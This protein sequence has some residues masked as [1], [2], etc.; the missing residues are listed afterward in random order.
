MLKK[1]LPVLRTLGFLAVAIGLLFRVLHWPYANLSITIGGGLIL[2]VLLLNLVDGGWA[3]SSPEEKVRLA[4]H[5]TILYGFASFL[6]FLPKLPFGT[7]AIYSGLIL[8][9]L[10]AVIRWRAKEEDPAA[11]IDEIGKEP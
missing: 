4:G 9:G 6:N 5:L 2:L 1:I 3:V 11:Q 7:Q 8:L 10:A